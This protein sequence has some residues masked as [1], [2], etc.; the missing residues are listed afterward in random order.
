M[1]PKDNHPTLRQDQPDRGKYPQHKVDVC[2]EEKKYDI[3]PIN[4]F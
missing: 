1:L 3:G 4:L 2:T